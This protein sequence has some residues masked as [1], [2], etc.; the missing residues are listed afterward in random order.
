M[1]QGLFETEIVVT[2]DAVQL[3]PF[4]SFSIGCRLNFRRVPFGACLRFARVKPTPE[5]ERQ[6]P[7]VSKVRK[8]GWEDALGA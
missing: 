1:G 8:K 4:F 3:A 5:I 6:H 7:P 2:E